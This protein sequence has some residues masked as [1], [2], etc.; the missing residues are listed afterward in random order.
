MMKSSHTC[1]S[2]KR[3]FTGV[4]RLDGGTNFALPPKCYAFKTKSYNP[5]DA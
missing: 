2:L 3:A 4:S 5:Q 1:F